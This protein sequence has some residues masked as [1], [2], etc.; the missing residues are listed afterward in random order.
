MKRIAFF[1]LAVLAAGLIART[2]AAEFNA[3][4][5]E[6]NSVTFTAKQMGVPVDGRFRKVN[7]AISFD[8]ARPTTGST[9]IEI[10]LASIDA[11]SDEA[12]GEVV[13][14]QWFDV[15]RFPSARFVSSA[16]RAVGGNRYEAVGQLMLKG[17]SQEVV[18]PFTLQTQGSGANA[19]ATF[20]GSF[21]LK[22]AEFGIGEGAWADFATVAND[23]PIRFQFVVKAKAAK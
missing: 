10:D 5:P 14:K 15:K 11:G 2:H 20:S 12:N 4:Q 3:V 13:G 21:V 16:V 6:Q 8:P 18:A 17:R 9:L 23:I 19:T 22:R 7:A 1:V